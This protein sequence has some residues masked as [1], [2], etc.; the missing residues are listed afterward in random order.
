MKRFARYILYTLILAPLAWFTFTAEGQRYTDLFMLRM[1]GASA[2]EMQL[3]QV[4]PHVGEKALIDALT[5]VNFT[6][7]DNATPYGQRTC[8]ARV[9]SFNGVPSSYITLFFANGG[10]TGLKLAYHARYH[11]DLID[12]LNGA[13]GPAQSSPT[14]ESQPKILHWPTA[15]GMAMLPEAQPPEAGAEMLWLARPVR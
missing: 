15:Y 7:R 14:A 5:N 1:F 3:A 8:H 4:G 9:A 10:L 13:L 2:I 12:N 6:C 11:Q